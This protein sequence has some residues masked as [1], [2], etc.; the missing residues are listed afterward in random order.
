MDKSK[1]MNKNKSSVDTSINSLVRKNSMNYIKQICISSC[2][3]PII[4][5][6][7]SAYK[8]IKVI[9]VTR[10]GTKT[11]PVPQYTFKHK[12]SHIHLSFSS[13]IHHCDARG[14]A[15][16]FRPPLHSNIEFFYVSQFPSDTK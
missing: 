9:P 14:E 7:Q 10:T 13:Y 6:N 1:T 11:Y 5:L 16:R 3:I 12:N 8:H 15:V 4:I 2:Y